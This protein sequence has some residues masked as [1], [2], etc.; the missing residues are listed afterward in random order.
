MANVNVTNVSVNKHTF[1]NSVRLI[2]QAHRVG[3]P[4]LG[5]DVI[6]KTGQLNTFTVKVDLKQ[7]IRAWR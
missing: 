4:K 1:C 6:K 5:R 7:P 2:E 3:G